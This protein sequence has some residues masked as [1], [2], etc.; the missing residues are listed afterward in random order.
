MKSFFFLLTAVLLASSC[1]KKTA[2]HTPATKLTI[3]A[4]ADLKF[5][6]DEL[7]AEYRA[8]NP[9]TEV[10]VTYGSSGNFF[11]QIRNEAP[12]DLYFSADI[13]YPRK[14]ADAGHA[15]DNDVFLYALGR[16]VIWVPRDSPI[17]VETLGIAAL[18]HPS[19]KKIAIATPQHAPYGVA[20][21]AALKSL[22]AYEG[23]EPKLVLGENIAQ[24]AQFIQ[25]GAADIGVIALSLAIGPQMKDLGKYWEIPLE[26]YPTMEQGGMILK[27]TSSP[28]AAKS[29]RDHVL[30]EHGRA[31]LERYGFL[32]PQT[33]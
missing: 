33:E 11:A 28:D 30:G 23:A 6:L 25:S 24:T 17:D 27:R 19:V 20:A 5:A 13:A 9:E 7:I 31:L 14:L 1:G 26:A 8:A 32:L 18:S 21:V 3:A 12:F 16:I 22:G 15:L 29:L 2:A 4:A 10:S